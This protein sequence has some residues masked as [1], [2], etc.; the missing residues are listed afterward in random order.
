MVL[1]TLL[2]TVISFLAF[3]YVL[4]S[5]FTML[6]KV[7]A[8]LLILGGFSYYIH[9]VYDV[10]FYYGML[11]FKTG[12]GL[13][14]IDTIAKKSKLWKWFADVGLVMSFG[15]LTLYFYPHVSR[16]RLAVGLFLLLFSA[17]FILPMLYPV[18]L[19]VINLPYPTSKARADVG[20]GLLYL[21]ALAV[22]VFGYA[23]FTSVNL[24]IQ[25][26]NVGWGV[27][28]KFLGMS[29]TEVQPGASLILPGV[30]IPLVEGILALLFILFFHELSHAILARVGKI[31]LKSAGVLMF[32]FIPLGAFV[33]P[34]EKEL[35][36]ASGK[37]QGRVL[38][39]GST[40]NFVM[41][42]IAMGLY[43]LLVMLPV[44]VYDDGV[45][46]LSSNN[47]LFEKGDVIYGINGYQLV[48]IHDFFE[49]QS[50]FIKPNMELTLN[51]SRGTITATT[52]ENGKLGLVLGPRIKQDL[53]WYM[54]IRNFLALMFTLNFFIATVN[55]L[56]IPMFD[57]YRL[58]EIALS[59]HPLIVKGI[60]YAVAGAFLL[61]F[62][63]WFL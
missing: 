12:K 6:V 48:S 20:G 7:V 13:E 17:L 51:T 31:K 56:P 47:Q 4:S 46:V 32:G 49:V 25:G 24:L 21:M 52:N 19:S 14:H 33:D 5:P 43:V 61:N 18:A 27:L 35:E 45:V 58:L 26:L 59:K 22:V 53:I 2:L 41:S 57:G 54:F 34:D 55:L 44:N 36:N 3:A 10:S 29:M 28:A 1:R 42:F 62:L 60:S 38:V 50:E 63:P 15:L 8:S 23:I 37:V 16:K 9:R 39:A 40:A 11:M 30:N